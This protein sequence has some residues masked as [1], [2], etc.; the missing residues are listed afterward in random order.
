MYKISTKTGNLDPQILGRFAKDSSIL[1]GLVHDFLGLFRKNFTRRYRILE[2]FVM[3]I[4]VFI[5]SR[6]NKKQNN[7][8]LV[9]PV[10]RNHLQL[11]IAVKLGVM[12]TYR[13]EAR[14]NGDL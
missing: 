2:T 1:S 3:D 4:S 8:F 7:I 14:G 13:I 10:G 6:K 12:V 9:V 5:V 11:V